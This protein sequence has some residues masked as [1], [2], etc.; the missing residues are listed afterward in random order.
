MVRH[1]RYFLAVADE[2][3]FSR[4]A[5]RLGIAQP[6]LS[7]AIR[8]LEEH[9][10]TPLF[11]RTSRSVE[12][13]SQGQS[14]VPRARGIIEALEEL[15]AIVGRPTETPGTLRIALPAGV[16]GAVLTHGLHALAELVGAAVEPVILP[17]RDRARA[18]Q[19][20][21]GDAAVLPARSSLST[22][23]TP[24]QAA[25]THSRLGVTGS[26]GS[27]PVHPSDLAGLRVALDP[28]DGAGLES[29][30]LLDLLER[31][32]LPVDA[33]VLDLD[34][35]TVTTRAR[36]GDLHLI[37]TAETARAAELTWAPLH[38]RLLARTTSVRCRTPWPFTAG[39]E[40]LAQW[41][42]ELH[43][44][45]GATSDTVAISSRR[46]DWGL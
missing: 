37:T 45:E 36:L 21:E 40:D 46:A 4:A 22:T 20:G 18:L 25:V 12:L 7:Q 1:L 30:R 11:R 10:G 43:P 16:P 26:S 41:W 42:R 34:H 2:L 14:L 6:P 15:P 8:R 31:F 17:P 39:P 24:D 33:L 23:R 38:H 32:G 3:H 9:L 5:D 19:A 28:E 13:T 35:A 29:A 27:A 44:D